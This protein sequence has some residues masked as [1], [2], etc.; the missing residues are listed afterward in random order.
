MPWSGFASAALRAAGSIGGGL[1]SQQGGYAG[2]NIDYVRE[3]WKKNYNA[4]KEFAQNGIRWKVEDAKAAGLHP[5]AGLGSGSYYTPSGSIGFEQT[6]GQGQDYSWLADAGQNIGRAIDAKATAEERAKAEEVNDEANFL[7]LENMRLQNEQIKLDMVSQIARDVTA[8]QRA[9][10]NTALP[11]AM[12]SLRTRADGAMVGTVMPG[13]GDSTTSSLFTVKPAE[14]VASHPETP[15]AEAG[16]HPDL[17]WS[18]TAGGGY[19][20]VRSQ[21]LADRLDDDYLGTLMWNIRNGL[22]SRISNQQYAPPRTYLPDNGRD[23]RWTWV[24]DNLNG[25]WVPYH[26]SQPRSRALKIAAGLGR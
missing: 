7:K 18:R 14:L 12:P 4:Q 20:P 15:Y 23:P 26:T 25:D 16:S 6:G 1:L 22:N 9:I 17:S 13:Q 2:T 10:R 21:G 11:P 19:A 5:L 3:M 24:F 8:S